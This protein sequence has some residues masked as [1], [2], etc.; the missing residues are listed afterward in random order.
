MQ[1][2]LTLSTTEK[3]VPIKCYMPFAYKVTHYVLAHVLVVVR[4]F[5]TDILFFAA[6]HRT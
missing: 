4:S 6:I 3:F 1:D 5:T 2:N